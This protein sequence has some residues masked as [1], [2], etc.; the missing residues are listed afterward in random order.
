M[1]WSSREV[2]FANEVTS[3][4]AADRTI[5]ALSGN[6]GASTNVSGNANKLD[7]TGKKRLS[8]RTVS[9]LKQKC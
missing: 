8:R 6:P 9:R 4:P 3:G 1:V 2:G 5:Y 7:L